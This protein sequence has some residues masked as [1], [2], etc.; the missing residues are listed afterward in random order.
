MNDQRILSKLFVEELRKRGVL[1]DVICEYEIESLR[2]CSYCHRLMNQGWMYQGY[3]TYCSDKCLIK[4]HPEEDIE[5]LKQ[6]A[7]RNDTDTYWTAWE[8]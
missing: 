2:E 8:G 4:A 3:E 5:E 6:E 1:E 7:A